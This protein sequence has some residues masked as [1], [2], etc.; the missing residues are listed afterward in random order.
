MSKTKPT[1]PEFTYEVI[2]Q[3]DPDTGDLL[4]PLPPEL[5][6]EMGWTEGTELDL[7]VDDQGRWVIQKKQ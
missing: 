3:E 7:D 2:T 5:L 4:L 6:R 1:A